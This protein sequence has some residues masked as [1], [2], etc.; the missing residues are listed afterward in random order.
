MPYCTRL[1]WMTSVFEVRTAEN[2]SMSSR[3]RTRS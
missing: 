2:A 3:W 1:V